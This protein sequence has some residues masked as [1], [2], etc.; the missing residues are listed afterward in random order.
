MRCRYRYAIKSREDLMKLSVSRQTSGF[1][2]SGF[3][4]PVALVASS[5]LPD[6]PEARGLELGRCGGD[7]NRPAGAQSAT[8]GHSGLGDDDPLWVLGGVLCA[9]RGSKSACCGRP[10]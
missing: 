8:L 3:E 4:G 6:F 10:V 5:P 7:A 2:F 1:Q 9:K